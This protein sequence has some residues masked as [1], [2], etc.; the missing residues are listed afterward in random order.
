MSVV[1]VAAMFIVSTGLANADHDV[2]FGPLVKS[3][4]C[5][6]AVDVKPASAIV[7]SFTMSY[8]G[9]VAAT[10]SDTV[11]AEWQVIGTTS[12]C[13]VD[14]ANKKMNKKSATKINLAPQI[15]RNRY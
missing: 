12:T 8:T 9:G 7:C 4:D 15:D 6:A 5:P 10:I 14:Q 3:T 13:D 11:P 2:P 1:A